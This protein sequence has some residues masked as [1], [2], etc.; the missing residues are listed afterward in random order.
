MKNKITNLNL[1]FVKLR[2]TSIFCPKYSSPCLDFATNYGPDG[3]AIFYS[4]SMFEINNMS[5]EKIIVNGEICPQIYIIL[6]LK[7]IK[8]KKIITLVCLHLKSKVKN[9]LRREIQMQEVLKGIKIHLSGNRWK[10]NSILNNRHPILLC[11]D[12]NGEKFENFYEMIVNDKDLPN[13]V[14]AYTEANN[15]I[16]EPTTIKLRNEIMQKRGIDY[17][18]YRK[19]A[20]KLIGYLDLPKNDAL[21]DEQGLPN[22]R[23][24][25]DHLSLICDFILISN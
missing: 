16:K 12:F 9:Y 15:G 11:G 19:T 6:Q 7:H 1:S 10:E 23:Y 3:C 22:L 21:L 24:S 8:S 4:R 2:Y 20:L 25:S 17:I 13:L 5:C 18:F 14:D